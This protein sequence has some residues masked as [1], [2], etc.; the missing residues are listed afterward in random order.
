MLTKWDHLIDR[1]Y[2]PKSRLSQFLLLMMSKPAVLPGWDKTDD[3]NRGQNIK[4]VLAGQQVGSVG[5]GSVRFQF[6]PNIEIVPRP[7]SPY[8]K[9][10]RLYYA[11]GIDETGFDK[12]KQETRWNLILNIL[13]QVAMIFVYNLRSNQVLGHECWTGCQTS[14]RWWE[15]EESLEF[16]KSQPRLRLGSHHSGPIISSTNLVQGW[17]AGGEWNMAPGRLVTFIGN[18]I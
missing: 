7:T 5:L 17:T 18:V 4:L 1:L 2:R 6:H 9:I 8:G 12:D 15:K 14:L 13:S 11:N 10:Y 16:W 3:K